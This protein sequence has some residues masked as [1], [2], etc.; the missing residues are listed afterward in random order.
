M[1]YDDTLQPKAWKRYP[2]NVGIKRAS[3]RKQPPPFNENFKMHLEYNGLFDTWLGLVVDSNREIIASEIKIGYE[4]ER[5]HVTNQCFSRSIHW[6]S[7][8]LWIAVVVRLDS[9]TPSLDKSSLNEL[10]KSKPSLKSL[11]QFAI[12]WSFSR[13]NAADSTVRYDN[14]MLTMSESI[15]KLVQL[16][17]PVGIPYIPSNIDK[18]FLQSMRRCMRRMYAL[19]FS[20]TKAEIIMRKIKGNLEEPAHQRQLRTDAKLDRQMELVMRPT[21]IQ[22]DTVTCIGSMF[23]HEVFACCLH[24]DTVTVPAVGADAWIASA[25]CL[26]QLVTGSRSIG[27]SLFNRIRPCDR[28]SLLPGAYERRFDADELISVSGLSKEISSQRKAS[29]RAVDGN[30]EFSDEAFSRFVDS[31]EHE[32]AN[33]TIVKPLLTRFLDPRRYDT[34]GCDSWLSDPNLKHAEFHIF[35][36]LFMVVRT[37]IQM[38]LCTVK[39]WDLWYFD[40]VVIGDRQYIIPCVRPSDDRRLGLISDSL[41]HQTLKACKNVLEPVDIDSGTHTLR[42]LYVNYSY[43]LYARRTMKEV[44]YARLVLGHRSF[45]VSLFY[46]SIHVQMN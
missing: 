28:P 45:D 1:Q 15:H 33:R 43:Q 11:I 36:N 38:H 35:F 8:S 2:I 34:W 23:A 14:F 12:P 37:H 40:E 4:H 44:G 10:M 7:W 32:D 17:A 5:L 20:Q 19:K 6:Y 13:L 16:I 3:K 31:I 42:R 29:S 27:I 22:E 39:S 30:M 18:N 21:L 26:L 41:Y 25:L 24:W 46:T 9:F